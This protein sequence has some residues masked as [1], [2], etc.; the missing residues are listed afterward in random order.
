MKDLRNP[1]DVGKTLL[2][3]AKM[4]RRNHLAAN[5]V[6]IGSLI[7]DYPWLRWPIPLSEIA[8]YAQGTLEDHV[9]DFPGGE[10]PLERYGDP[11]EQTVEVVT[12][13][14]RLPIE[15]LAGAGDAR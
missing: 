15:R 6:P 8:D 4:Y 14:R 1:R 10:S 12:V 11:R 5:G 3:A 7:A 13:R 2:H 9:P